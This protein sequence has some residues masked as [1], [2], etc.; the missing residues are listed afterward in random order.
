MRRLL[1]SS[2]ICLLAG[3]S[4]KPVTQRLY[5]ENGKQVYRTTCGGTDNSISQCMVQANFQ[6]DGEFFNLGSEGSTRYA[7]VAGYPVAIVNR[8]L[9]F[10]CRIEQPL[11]AVAEPVRST[12]TV[13]AKAPS[14]AD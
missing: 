9:V 3:C 5:M 14:W 1:L 10:K 12:A 6:C 13:K 2:S 11:P 4:S 8:E 7:D